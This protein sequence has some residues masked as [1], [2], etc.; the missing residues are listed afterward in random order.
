[1]NYR[2]SETSK[3]QSHCGMLVEKCA[4]KCINS[5]G[6]P[7]SVGGLN[8]SNVHRDPA[9]PMQRPFWNVLKIAILPQFT[10]NYRILS[11]WDGRPP[12]A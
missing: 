7:F 10:A 11:G 12:P 5:W 8:L 1:M 3:K 6:P 4:C 9:A 2:E